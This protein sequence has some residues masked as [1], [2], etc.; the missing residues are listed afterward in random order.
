ME[1]LIDEHLF[2]NVKIRELSFALFN[3][4]QQ[5]NLSNYMDECTMGLKEWGKKQ[6]SD[7]GKF[8]KTEY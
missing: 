1:N 7:P 6:C 3:F 2:Y 5:S 8:Q 4:G